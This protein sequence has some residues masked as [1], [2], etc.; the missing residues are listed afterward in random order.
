MFSLSKEYIYIIS[1]HWIE[2]KAAIWKHTNKQLNVDVRLLKYFKEEVAAGVLSCTSILS[3][4]SKCCSQQN[5]V[6]NP[7]PPPG[8]SGRYNHMVSLDTDFTISTQ[9]KT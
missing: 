1:V 6:N 4:E 5:K 8:L 2:M 3:K 9:I 7:L